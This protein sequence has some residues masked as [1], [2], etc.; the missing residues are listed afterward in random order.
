MFLRSLCNRFTKL[1]QSKINYNRCQAKRLYSNAIKPKLVLVENVLCPQGDH[2]IAHVKL[3]N[4]PVNSLT[5][6]LIEELKVAIQDAEK[7]EDVKSL[8]LGSGVERGIFSAGLDLNQTYNVNKKDFIDYWQSFENLF[9][10]LYLSPLPTA[11]IIE[12]PCVAGGL[13]L[14]LACDMRISG[15]SEKIQLGFTETKIGLVP[16]KWVQLLVERTV[17]APTHAEQVL[18]TGHMLNVE[19]ASGYN[20]I[21]HIAERDF[22]NVAALSLDVFRYAKPEARAKLKI[23]QHQCVIDLMSKQS[24]EEFWKS[25]SSSECQLALASIIKKKK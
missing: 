15:A 24:S 20:F 1:N 5:K 16:P 21:H 2:L 3:N 11:C 4:T 10:T 9:K 7:N 12:G 18:Q 22:Y 17:L 13:I 6:P 23:M 25:V 19:D 14:A 8:I